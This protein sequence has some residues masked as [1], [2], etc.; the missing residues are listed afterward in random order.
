MVQVGFGG[1]VRPAT[2]QCHKG[3]FVVHVY[4]VISG[5][6]S[7][8][9]GARPFATEDEANSQ[10]DC[11]VKEIAHDFLNSIGLQPELASNVTVTHGDEAVKAEQ[12]VRNNNN[13]R[14]H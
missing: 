7:E 11:V 8:N 10:L 3:Q 2:C 14:L 4:A 5:G 9:L 13:P 6:G 12:R 1:E